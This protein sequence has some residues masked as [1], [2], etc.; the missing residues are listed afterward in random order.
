MEI[1]RKKVSLCIELRDALTNRSVAGQKVSI[2]VNGYRP[3]AHKEKKYYIFQIQQCSALEVCITSEN[4]EPKDLMLSIDGAKEG[5]VIDLYPDG[6]LLHIFHTPVL[7]ILLPPGRA[8][9][10]MEGQIWKE[11]MGQS[12]EIISVVKNPKHYF[13]LQEDYVEGDRIVFSIPG[14]EKCMFLQIEDADQKENFLVIERDE[15]GHCQ[16]AAPLQRQY[17]KGSRIYEIYYVKADAEG[18][19]AGIQYI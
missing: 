9:P 8:Y 18:K 12:Q 19:A 3:I 14:Q 1:I 6:W 10:L 5:K 13:L 4:Y 16:L 7:T 17:S 11:F 2:T 15:Q